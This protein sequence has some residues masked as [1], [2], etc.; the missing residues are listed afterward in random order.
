M[1]FNKTADTISFTKEA[2]SETQRMMRKIQT[3]ITAEQSIVQ[4]SWEK[5]SD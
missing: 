5:R 3:I 2:E 1:I 4:Y